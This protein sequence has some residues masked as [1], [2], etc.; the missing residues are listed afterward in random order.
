[1]L[2]RAN[3][4]TVSKVPGKV[5]SKKYVKHIFNEYL[6]LAWMRA[7]LS[8]APRG[9]QRPLSRLSAVLSIVALARVCP[10]YQ[11]IF[12]YVHTCMRVCPIK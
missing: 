9:F 7:S 5:D 11:Y 12:M 3:L 1:M 6:S 8:L 10:L 2:L 4:T